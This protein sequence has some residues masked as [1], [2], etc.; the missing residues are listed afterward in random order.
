MHCLD[1]SAVV[2]YLHGVDELGAF[3][4][5][6]EA[7]P[8]F[9]PTVSLHEAFV[10]AVRLG[11]ADGLAGVQDD[12]DWLEPIPLTIDGA[13]EAATIDGELHDSGEPIGPLDTLIAGIVRSVGGTIVTRDDHFERVAGLS[14]HRYD[15]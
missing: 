7:K 2:D 13:A 8:V 1:V 12:L 11:G 10:G 5:D 3:L 6:Y 14:V 4:R 9:A 15:D